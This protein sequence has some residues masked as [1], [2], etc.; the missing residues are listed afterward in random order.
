MGPK[1]KSQGG[2]AL[3][4]KKFDADGCSNDTTC[5][6]QSKEFF[7]YALEY[8]KLGFSVIP[9][10]PGPEKKPLIKW[11]PYQEQRASPDTIRAW[12]AKWPNANVGIITGAIS[13]II[14]VD[15]DGPVG[16]EGYKATFGDIPATISQGTGRDGGGLHLLF[17]HPG[18]DR[19]QNTESVLCQKV[20]TRGDGGYIVAAPSVHHTGRAY[21][22]NIDPTEMGLD[23]LL[24]LPDDLKA[25]L[26]VTN[27]GSPPANPKSQEHEAGKKY[28]PDKLEKAR[29][30]L[31]HCCEIIRE[32][33][34][35][36]QHRTRRN[37]ARLIGGY[38]HHYIDENE[39][40][41]ALEQAVVD[42][43]AKNMRSS[44]DTIRDGIAY[45]KSEPITIPD[46]QPSQSNN[47]SSPPAESLF[48]IAKEQYPR[49]SFPWDVLPVKI[50]ESLQQ[51]ARACATS[52]TSLPGA[53]IAIF[54]STIGNTINVCPKTNWNEPLILWCGDIRPS[55]EGK[56]PP[57]RAL[58]H[59]LYE[60]QQMAN[61]AYKLELDAWDLLSKKDRGKPPDKPRGYYV[62]DLT[63]EG[64]RTDHSGHGGKV[65]VL[66]ELSSFLTSQN[67][68]KKKGSDR[69]SWLCLHDG[70]PAR[71]VRAKETLTLTGCRIS[72]FGGI[73]PE[74]WQKI[75]S[76]NGGLHLTD[77]TIYR[78]LPTYE[79]KSYHP[80]TKESW[81]DDNRK[82]WESLL[83]NA[84][85][86]AD[87]QKKSKK[88]ILSVGAQETFFDWR[89]DLFQTKDDLP[90]QVRGFIPKLTGYALRFAG[91]LYLMHR[92]SQGQEIGDTIHR[93]YIEKGIRISEFYLGHIVC[94]MEAL[95]GDVSSPLELIEQVIH[96]A[97]TLKSLKPELDSG[98]LAVGYIHEKFNATC[99]PEQKINTARAMGALLRHCKLT[100]P[101]GTFNANR[102]ESVKC[103]QWDAKTDSFIETCLQC[104][105]SLQT[106]DQ[107]GLKGGDIE[108]NKVSKVSGGDTCNNQVETLETLKKRR[109]QGETGVNTS[110]GDIGDIGDEFSKENK[111]PDEQEF[112]DLGAGCSDV[113]EDI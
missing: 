89:N 31:A 76:E 36:E 27:S 61:D 106:K 50:A 34:E 43:G 63:L 4:G 11:K 107:Q 94:A 30:V 101:G 10:K 24:D 45:G 59:V 7:K 5:S 41:S 60:A 77:G 78:F 96:L 39:V 85:I 71:I 37:E 102:K 80:L 86:W 25:A 53:A 82:A 6:C 42:S 17:K 68:Y 14:V 29:K 72:L 44:M 15:I 109:L 100:I 9:I 99:K 28:D 64:L 52:S 8:E 69:E 98:R 79:G 93:D 95:T 67:Q 51:L 23:D 84:L 73:Q 16:L 87:N 92:F 38:I 112:E 48:D 12:W 32:S 91:V 20:D 75:F 103:L 33:Q 58:M 104:L 21:K 47:D 13:N 97:K 74:I 62:T 108:K 35:G 3:A 110:N 65:C 81:S 56:T 22:W 1:R 105:Q 113:D 46:I 83:R 70:N 57:P 26:L 18:G 111:K 19:F 40:L 54:A 55:G 49:T 90:P 66:D 88:L 2:E